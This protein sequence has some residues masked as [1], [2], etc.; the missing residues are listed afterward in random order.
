MV[1]N[2]DWTNSTAILL[3]P[4]V[5]A[6]HGEHLFSVAPTGRFFNFVERSLIYNKGAYGCSSFD[7]GDG[8]GGDG[9]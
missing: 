6:V 4:Q 3:S 2:S 1:G 8:G 5:L 7:G 9:G